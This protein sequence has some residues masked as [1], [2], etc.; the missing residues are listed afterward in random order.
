MSET[1]LPETGIVPR[2]PFQLRSLPIELRWEV[3]RRHPY[4]LT[5]WKR[6]RAFH[7]NEPLTEVSAEQYL[8]AAAI[9]TLGA[10]GISGEPPDPSTPFDELGESDLHR[11]WLTG[12]VHPISLRGLAAIL[13]T[14]LPKESLTQVGYLFMQAGCDDPQDGMPKRIE[15]LMDL[16][17]T[18]KPGLNSYPDEPL[19][20]I[21]PAAS[22]RNV[23]ESIEELLR[24]W[25]SER[26]LREQ[27]TRSDRYSSF[28]AA[29][30]LREGWTG[31]GYDLSRE[32]KFRE[33]AEETGESLSNVSSQYR[34]A[35][36]LIIGHSY[37]PELWWRTMGAMKAVD[38]GLANSRVTSRRPVNSP[39]RR[40]VPETQLG[41]DIDAVARPAGGTSDSYSVEE[42]LMDIRSLVRAGRSDEEVMEQ[43]EMSDS[44]DHRDLIG[45]FRTQD[46]D[47]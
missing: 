28:L 30:D 32:L 41:A 14:A 38:G 19:V 22:A 21:N 35:F 26:S 10:I 47:H 11:A 29:W 8:R 18:D 40:P 5:W 42:L 43:L 27:R 12:A 16:Q 25:K 15:S 4:Y 20:S 7:R 37:Q 36:E 31:S 23:S 39:T 46:R 1:E 13:L 6:S 45:W 24:Q 33:V 34:R 3:T 2:P 44:P 17:A 9:T